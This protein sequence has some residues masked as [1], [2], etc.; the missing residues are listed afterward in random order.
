[1]QTLELRGTASELSEVPQR[2]Y[3]LFLEGKWKG[4]MWLTNEQADVVRQIFRH[5]QEE[6]TSANP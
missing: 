3:D 6:T 4:L 5:G 2:G 1:M